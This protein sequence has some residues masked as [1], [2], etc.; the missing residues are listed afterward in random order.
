MGLATLGLLSVLSV[1]TAD[2]A[3]AQQE[4]AE[5][6]AE[7][8]NFP[9]S[10]QSMQFFSIAGQSTQVYRLPIGVWLRRPEAHPWGVKLRTSVSF[11]SYDFEL[12]QG[13]GQLTRRLE[14]V[15]ILPGVELYV[16]LTENWTLKPFIEVGG[17]RDLNARE[18]SLLYSSG[19]RSLAIFRRKGYDL[20][21]GNRI[22]YSGSSLL[23]G[24]QGGGFGRFEVG[25]EMMRPLGFELSGNRATW[26]LFAAH[27]R[28]FDLEI[29][30]LAGTEINLDYQHEVGV[31]VGTEPRTKLWFFKAPRVGVSYRWAPGFTAWLV[32][33][34][35]PY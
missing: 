35:F 16:P 14:T 3:G 11:G 1:A 32:N 9:F 10:S 24:G 6:N 28:Y 15:S 22:D 7:L 12:S 25:L 20:R 19:V 30:D 8:I 31:T 13:A 4:D 33:F 26:S 2:E 34:G 27:R 17:G 5:S 29:F 21:L 18:W 23:D